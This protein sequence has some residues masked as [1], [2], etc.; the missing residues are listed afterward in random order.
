ME[1]REFIIAAA[2]MLGLT[3]VGA[4]AFTTGSVARDI[5]VDI[6]ADDSAVIG[7]TPGP[8]AAVTIDNDV[9]TI[10]TDTTESDGLNPD[11]DFEYGDDQDPTTT[12]AFSITNNDG[13]THDFTVGM[14]DFSLGG[15]SSFEIELYQ[16]DETHIGTVNPSTD[17]TYSGQTSTETIYAVMKLDTDGLTSVDDMNGTLTISAE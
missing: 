12:Y 2:G 11:G 8:V 4:I 13:N 7:L 1:R 3:S 15:S 14:E 6:A 16:D 17:V 9:L 5:N 10:D